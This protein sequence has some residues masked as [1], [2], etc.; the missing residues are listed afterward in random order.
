M[1][2][3]QLEPTTVKVYP[4]LLAAMLDAGLAPVGRVY[5]LLKAKDHAGRGCFD[6]AE[7]RDLLTA[8][9]SSW[10][11]CGRRRLRGILAD[12]D[13]T[14]WTRDDRDRIWLHGPAR[15]AQA[16]DC[17]RLRGVPVALPVAA[18]LAG[19]A[20][21]KAAFLASWHAGRVDGEGNSTP[22]SQ[23]AIRKETGVSE[24]TARRYH[25]IAGVKTQRNIAISDLPWREHMADETYER[26]RGVFR[27]VDRQ[28]KRGKR[29]RGYVAWHMPATYTAPYS[30]SPKGRQRKINRQIDLVISTTRG[31][32]REV[33]RLYYLKGSA[34][35]K[36]HS[37]QPDDD[38]YLRGKPSLIPDV[39]QLWD[40][41]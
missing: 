15:I 9:D 3:P 12:G 26:G 28:G 38:H 20:E 7:V 33:N 24:V 32:S 31:N 5:E 30:Q 13:G 21:T 35:A 22:I 4:P 17:G 29:G 37:R 23:A 19:L 11:V 39:T 10:R 27:F 6:I 18:L 8:K 34:A 25:K 14:C 1:A 2:T 16:L 40:A 36:A 41:L